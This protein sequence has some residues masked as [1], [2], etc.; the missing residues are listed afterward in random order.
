MRILALPLLTTA[1]LAACSSPPLDP[2]APGPATTL[3]AGGDCRMAGAQ[4][5]LGRTADAT[6]L[7]EAAQRAGARSARV[8]RPNQVIT[9]EFN[10]Q[11]LN[12][13]VDA[14]NKV[15]AVRCG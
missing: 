5:A 7:T 12:L 4:F 6:L 8:L 1:L 13:E 3:P 15:V 2:K 14:G 10:A 9:M 11:R